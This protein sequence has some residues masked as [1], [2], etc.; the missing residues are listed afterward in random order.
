MSRVELP[1]F[2]RDVFTDVERRNVLFACSLA[3]LAVGLVPHLLSPGL[4]TAQEAIRQRP[5]IQNLF[6][7][8]AFSSTAAILVGG[9]VSDIYRHRSLL[10]GGLALMTAGS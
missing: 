5:E 7:L 3:V 8:L 9:L 10:V 4:P 2:I 6:L 1:E